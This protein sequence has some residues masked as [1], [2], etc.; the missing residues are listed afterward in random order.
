MG[1]GRGTQVHPNS[2]GEKIIGKKSGDGLPV[3]AFEFKIDAI[4][5]AYSPPLGG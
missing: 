3:A 5:T 1:F 2:L 4:V